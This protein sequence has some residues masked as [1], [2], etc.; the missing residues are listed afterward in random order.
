MEDTEAFANRVQRAMAKTLNLGSMELLEEAEIPDEVGA[1][2]NIKISHGYSSRQT[3]PTNAVL[4]CDEASCCTRYHA[5]PAVERVSSYRE[6]SVGQRS[7][8]LAFEAADQD[9]CLCVC[10]SCGV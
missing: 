10:V 7:D 6:A 3:P 2:R 9:L 4:T 8:G 1:P 5:M